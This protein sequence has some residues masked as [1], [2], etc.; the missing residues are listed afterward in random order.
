MARDA[1]MPKTTLAAVGWRHRVGQGR[2][3]RCESPRVRRRT[4]VSPDST[5]PAGLKWVRD[6]SHLVTARLSRV[7][8]HSD[9]RATSL[10]SLPG[11]EWGSRCVRLG[12]EGRHTGHSG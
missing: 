9:G 2:L 1:R 12:T 5:G 7:V 11:Y 3:R 6:T 10:G 4:G 8:A